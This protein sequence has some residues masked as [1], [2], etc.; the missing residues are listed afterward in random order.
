[1]SNTTQVHWVKSTAGKWL[2]LQFVDLSEV[3]TVGVYIIWHGGQQPRVVRIGQGDIADRL[4]KHGA[5]DDVLAYA[6][7]GKLFVTW[8]AVPARLLDGVERYLAEHWKPLIGDRFPHV[9]PI[10]VNSPF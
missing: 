6:A 1:M 7:A 4:A 8:A 9:A 2:S 3:E 5:D 10:A